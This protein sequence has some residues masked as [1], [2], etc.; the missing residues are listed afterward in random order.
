MRKASVSIP[1][2]KPIHDP[3]TD[4]SKGWRYFFS[5]HFRFFSARN[6]LRS[7]LL[8]FGVSVSLLYFA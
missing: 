8:S 3:R 7:S 6:F 4:T 5:C 1:A 2:T